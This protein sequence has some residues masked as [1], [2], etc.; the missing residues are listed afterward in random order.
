METRRS[1]LIGGAALA[2]S[3]AIGPA[4][5]LPP[6]SRLRLFSAARLADRDGAMMWC[7]GETTKF[8]LPAR[9]HGVVS[10]TPETI[11][12]SARRPGQFI[13]V[14]NA[15]GGAPPRIVETDTRYHVSG[16]SAGHPDGKHLAT[17][18]FDA[19]T[20]R[21]RIAIRRPED[22]KELDRWSLPGIEPHDLVFAHERLI[23]AIG[24]LIRDGGVSGPAI[25]PDGVDSSVLE[26]DASTGKVLAQHK[27]PADLASLSLRHLAR[28]PDGTHVVVA[29]QDQDLSMRRPLVAIIAVGQ[30]IRPLTMPDPKACDFRGYAGSVAVDAS[31]SVAAV[32]SPRGSVVGFWSIPDGSWLGG[33][34]LADACGLAAGSNA[35]EFWASSGLGEVVRISVPVGS[36]PSPIQRW[37]TEAQ[38]DNHLLRT[39]G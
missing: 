2:C 34:A 31:G 13:A 29:M 3:R 33:L 9:G 7:P 4:V 18:E 28:T 24:G 19:T 37:R 35:R 16:H 14:L 20:M 12:L 23:V 39:Q 27:L 15:N 26:I 38:F 22:G 8:A 10:L 21:A 5:A 6:D 32:S 30:G 1:V 11:V 25:N 17:S 36:P